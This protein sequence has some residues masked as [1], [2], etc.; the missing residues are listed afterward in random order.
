MRRSELL[1]LQLR[2]ASIKR[3]SQEAIE[4]PFSGEG[5]WWSNYPNYVS[6]AGDYNAAASSTGSNYA[7]IAKMPVPG[8]QAVA[9][10]AGLDSSTPTGYSVGGTSAG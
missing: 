7:A 5:Y 10:R 8:V 6:G 9:K 4:P 2:E 1:S 3:S